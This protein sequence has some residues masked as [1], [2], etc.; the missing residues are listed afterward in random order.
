[1]GAYSL[2]LVLTYLSF[3]EDSVREDL[4]EPYTRGIA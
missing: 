1:M 4:C 3:G 2:V